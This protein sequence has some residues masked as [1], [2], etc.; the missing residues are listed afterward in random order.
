MANR[1]INLNKEKCDRRRR[2]AALRDNVDA[3]RV[4]LFRSGMRPATDERLTLSVGELPYDEYEALYKINLSMELTGAKAL[5]MDD[6]YIHYLEAGNNNFIADRYMFLDDTTLK[7]VAER[8][9]KGIAF[10]N[11]HRTGGLSAPSEL[12]FGKSFAGRYEEFSQPDGSTYKRSLLGVYMLRGVHPNGTAGPSTDDLHR[13]IESGTLTDVS[14]GLSGGERVCNVCAKSLGEK[15]CVHVPGTHKDMSAEDIEASKGLGIKDGR[16]SYTVR[17]ADVSE[18]SA[19]YKGAVPGAGFRKAISFAKANELGSCKLEAL[20]TYG[21]L[22]DSSE[23]ALFKGGSLSSKGTKKMD[24]LRWIGIGQSLGALDAESE[25]DLSEVT[26]TPKPAPVAPAPAPVAPA[27]QSEKLSVSDEERA[28]FEREKRELKRDKFAL[29][30][31]GFILELERENKI[32]P[33]EKPDVKRAYVLAALDDHYNPLPDE[34]GKPV[35]RLSVFKAAQTGRKDHGLTKEEVTSA[36]VLPS[37]DSPENP[38]VP[39]AQRLAALLK[40]TVF[41]NEVLAELSK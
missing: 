31:D 17:S 8:G 38:N 1:D 15:D 12:P 28:A 19:V 18:V 11:S 27:P 32:T 4:V 39:T 20:S 25:V 16:A 30:A 7:H 14:L 3:T 29:E 22:M 13:S 40:G 5:S 24:I 35:S 36:E 23:K 33:A 26:A 21:D 10:M 9:D 34:D 41:G 2:I 37:G 6:V